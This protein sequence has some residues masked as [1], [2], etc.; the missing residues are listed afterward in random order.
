VARSWLSIHVELIEGAGRALSPNDC[1]TGIAAADPS[2]RHRSRCERC[3]PPARRSFS[4]TTRGPASL[5]ELRRLLSGVRRAHE[6]GPVTPGLSS[7][8]VPSSTTAGTPVA[9]VT[10]TFPERP[11]GRPGRAALAARVRSAASRIARRIR[12]RAAEVPA[13]DHSDAAV[14][15]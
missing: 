11:G 15:G 3:S 13:V 2:P 14:D 4:G 6:D 7:V 12:G 1:G 10:L 9:A 8:A 5:S